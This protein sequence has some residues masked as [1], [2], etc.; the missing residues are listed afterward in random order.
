MNGTDANMTG[1]RGRGPVVFL[2]RWLLGPDEDPASL[3][4]RARRFLGRRTWL[5]F[6]AALTAGF[7]LG[8]LGGLL[9]YR[10]DEWPHPTFGLFVVPA[11][12]FGYLAVGPTRAMSVGAVVLSAATLGNL[13]GMLYGPADLEVRE[14]LGWTLVSVLVGPVL[15]WLGHLV[16]AQ[17][18][19]VRGVATGAAAAVVLLPL[20]YGFVDGDPYYADFMP[21]V[22]VVFDL[23]AVAVLVFLC[24]GIVP[25]L[26]AVGTAWALVW[27]LPLLHAAMLLVHVLVWWSKGQ[28]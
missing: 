17:W 24:R 3:P 28:W 19:I 15:G 16:G 22:T 6:L 18:R 14:Y 4:G 25:R 12:L 5:F 7:V 1:K 2:S 13:L 27:P 23:M 8:G 10:W 11:V 26:V 20:Y 21:R 9:V